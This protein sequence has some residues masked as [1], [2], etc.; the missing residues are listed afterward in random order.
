MSNIVQIHKYSTEDLF[1]IIF[2]ADL[3]T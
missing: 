1:L 3:H 2:F